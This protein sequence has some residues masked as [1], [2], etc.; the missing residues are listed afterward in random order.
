MSDGR[1]L[2]LKFGSCVYLQTVP[3]IVE[4]G[5]K[6]ERERRYAMSSSAY[7]VKRIIQPHPQIAIKEGFAAAEKRGVP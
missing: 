5:G 6:V 2:G 4:T 7:F 3:S 1:N